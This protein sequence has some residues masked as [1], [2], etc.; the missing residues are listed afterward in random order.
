VIGK[1]PGVPYAICTTQRSGSTLLSGLLEQTSVLGRPREMLNMRD[2]LKPLA[3]EWG[4]LT[5]GTTVDLGAYIAEFRRRFATPNGV[6]G[7][8]LHF[9]QLEPLLGFSPWRTFFDECRVILLLRKDVIAQAASL[10]LAR[11][12]EEWTNLRSREHGSAEGPNRRVDVQLDLKA[13]DQCLRIITW[14][15]AQ[16]LE[17]LSTNSKDYLI[18]T[19]E[20][21]LE[22][23]NAVCQQIADYCGVSIDRPVAMDRLPMKKQGNALNLEF[24]RAFR[25]SSKL[26]VY[27][28]AEQKEITLNGIRLSG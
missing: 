22:D 24:S 12:T 20:N 4:L 17:F 28:N 16:W 7:V 21:V 11:Q 1:G 13:F 18:V 14:Q 15:I 23:P 9:Y 25:E 2:V 6:F 19:Y 5:D 3:Q 8:K 26:F 27:A 10:Y